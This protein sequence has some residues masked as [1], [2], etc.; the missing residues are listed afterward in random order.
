MR[1]NQRRDKE[2]ELSLGY[3]FGVPQH[4]RCSG[5]FQ[6]MGVICLQLRRGDRLEIWFGRPLVIGIIGILGGRWDLPRRMNCGRDMT[7]EERAWGKATL[8]T[9]LDLEL[10]SGPQVLADSWLLAGP[11]E[12]LAKKFSW[13]FRE[14]L[15]KR[16]YEADSNILDHFGSS[17][18][19]RARQ[20]FPWTHSLCPSA[21]NSDPPP[22]TVLRYLA[23]ARNFENFPYG[24]S[25][26]L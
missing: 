4:P 16:R 1:R 14:S 10:S 6:H 26:N 3:E 18:T 17:V 19:S 9:S 7:T 21:L 8:H 15:G 23:H 5:A 12:L 13:G 20:V 25:F 24:I 22:R 2:H 11:Q